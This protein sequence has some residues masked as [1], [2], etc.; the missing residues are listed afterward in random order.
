VELV[1]SNE[2]L[3]NIESITD[4]ISNEY[5]TPQTAI[6]F[7]SNLFAFGNAIANHPE[8]YPICKYPIWANQNM[9]CAIY[10]KKWVFVFKIHK[11]GIVVYHIKNGKLLDY[12][13]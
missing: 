1:Y 9:R 3:E 8:A 10:K 13:I 12:K 11:N 6:K 4:Y 2:F 5:D 7:I